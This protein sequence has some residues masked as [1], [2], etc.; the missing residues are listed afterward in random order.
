[1]DGLH[2][3]TLFIRS[4]TA[5]GRLV[6]PA[7]LPGLDPSPG[8]PSRFFGARYAPHDLGSSFRGSK[9]SAAAPLGASS[10]E[11][12]DSPLHRLARSR[13][14]LGLIIPRRARLLALDSLVHSQQGCR[15]C[16]RSPSTT[17]RDPVPSLRSL[18]ALTASSVRA[19]VSLLRLTTGLEVRCVAGHPQLLPCGPSFGEPF[20]TA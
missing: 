13:Y 2:L 12:G 5:A 11:V 20:P 16:L 14:T 18:S 4:R 8:W 1:M 10:L 3:S 19:V 6:F 17:C 7:T 15:P 9:L